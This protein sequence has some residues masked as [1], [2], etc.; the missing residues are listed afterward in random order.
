MMDN[1]LI[2]LKATDSEVFCTVT[3]CSF[4][5]TSLVSIAAFV[6]SPALTCTHI[7]TKWMSE[8][9]TAYSSSAGSEQLQVGKGLPPVSSLTV[10]LL[11]IP[12]LTIY[13]TWIIE[14]WHTHLSMEIWKLSCVMMISCMWM[15]MLYAVCASVMV[16]PATLLQELVL[17][18]HHLWIHNCEKSRLIDLWG[19]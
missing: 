3:F 8:M 1:I 13:V 2:I 4:I 6:G 11:C 16:S 15:W 12:V 17:S 9:Y 5:I 10:S 14:Q 7:P 19:W 18:K